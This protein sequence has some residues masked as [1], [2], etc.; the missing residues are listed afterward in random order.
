[1][2]DR[3]KKRHEHKSLSVA[4]SETGK[5]PKKVD[6]LLEHN[7]ADLEAVDKVYHIWY[8]VGVAC[9]CGPQITK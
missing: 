2:L 4:K 3:G 8:I 6:K 1:M 5:I 9:L 7:R